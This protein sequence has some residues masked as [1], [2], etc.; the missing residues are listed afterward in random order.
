M[1]QPVTA[2][3]C[4]AVVACVGLDLVAVVASLEPLVDRRHRRRLRCSRLGASVGPGCR[5]RSLDPLVDQA[6]AA[7]GRGAVAQAGVGLDLVGV[8]ASSTP[9]GL[10]R[11]RRRLRQSLRQASVWTWLPSSQASTPARG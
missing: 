8:V 6:V 11:R 5:R 1:D 2:G 9:R 4:G 7:G 10:A 3:G